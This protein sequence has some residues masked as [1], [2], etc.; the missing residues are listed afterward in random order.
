MEFPGFLVD[1]RETE[2]KWN[3]GAVV[4]SSVFHAV[5]FLAIQA[6]QHSES[7]CPIFFCIPT[8]S[9]QPMWRS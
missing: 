4:L 8:A 9:V 1:G 6:A 2:C 7:G 3:A 5:L